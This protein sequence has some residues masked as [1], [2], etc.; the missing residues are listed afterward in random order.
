MP[1]NLCSRLKHVIRAG[2]RNML[3][4]E[5]KN[6]RFCCQGDLRKQT[7]QNDYHH[8]VIWICFWF[9]FTSCQTQDKY[10]QIV[11]RQFCLIRPTLLMGPLLS[12]FFFGNQK[13][14]CWQNVKKMSECQEHRV[15]SFRTF[16]IWKWLHWKGF[17]LKWK[18]KVLIFKTW[19]GVIIIRG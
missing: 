7:N 4:F 19:T 12:F 8:M 5:I 2:C 6:L 18:I 17:D 14:Q 11:R 16:A 1:Q 15:L 9:W 10:Q 3:C 13:C